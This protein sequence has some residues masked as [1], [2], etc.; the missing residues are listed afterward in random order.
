MLSIISHEIQENEIQGSIA[1]VGVYRGSFAAYIRKAFPERFFYL[2]DTFEGFESSQAKYNEETWNI[3]SGD[4]SNTSVD[5]VLKTIGSIDKCIVKKG[6]FPETAKNVDDPFVFV[7]L[8]VD[9]YLPTMDGL[10]FFIPNFLQEGIFS[11]TILVVTITREAEKPFE[12]FAQKTI[13]LS[14]LYV[15]ML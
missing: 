5:I 3:K 6:F 11:P 10:N 1:E 8:D 13:F 12:N 15:T 9:L 4:Y 2:F 14:P 7:S